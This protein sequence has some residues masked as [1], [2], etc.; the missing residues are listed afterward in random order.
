MFREPFRLE[1]HSCSDRQ[2][3]QSHRVIQ[4]SGCR[5]RILD[6]MRRIEAAFSVRDDAIALMFSKLKNISKHFCLCGT[7][8]ALVT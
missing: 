7:K 3:L 4:L 8:F 2:H 6:L 1:A 5:F